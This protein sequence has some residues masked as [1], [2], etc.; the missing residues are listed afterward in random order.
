MTIETSYFFEPD[1][2]IAVSFKCN[3]CG[4]K[5]SIP[6]S[7]IKAAPVMCQHCETGWITGGGWEAKALD[8]FLINLRKMETLLKD[9]PFTMRFE[10]ASL[11]G[12]GPE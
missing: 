5:A 11:K 2:I 10:V 6:S 9:R 7:Q 4:S 3:R 1:D 12:S 8:E